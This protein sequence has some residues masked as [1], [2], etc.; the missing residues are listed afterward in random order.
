MFKIIKYLLQRKNL[1][2]PRKNN[3]EGARL[4]TQE[5]REDFFKEGSEGL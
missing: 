3:N 1:K 2:L 5:E 4:M